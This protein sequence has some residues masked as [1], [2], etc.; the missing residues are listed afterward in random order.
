MIAK[1]GVRMKALG[2]DGLDGEIDADPRGFD[3][4][5]LLDDCFGDRELAALLQGDHDSADGAWAPGSQ[6]HGNHHDD[7]SAAGLERDVPRSV[8]EI[9]LL[10]PAR[11]ILSRPS[12]SFRATLV[13]ASYRLARG[14]RNGEAGSAHGASPPPELGALVEIV[15]AGSLVVDDVQDDSARR[16]GAATLHRLYGVPLAINTG[17]WLYFWPLELLSE[18][19]PRLG[20]SAH[21]EADLRRRFGRAMFRCHF[22]QALDLAVHVARLPQRWVPSVVRGAAELKT[23]TLTELAATV[24]AVAAGASAAHLDALARFGRRLGLGLQMLDDLGN[25]TTSAGA[26]NGLRP[27]GGLPGGRHAGGNR[28]GGNQ[29]GDARPDRKAREDKQLEDL[30]NGRPTWPWA[31]AAEHLPPDEFASLQLELRVLSAQAQAQGQEQWADSVDFRPL[32]ETLR[33]AVGMSGRRTAHLT[34]ERALAD[35]QAALGPDAAL[36]DLRTMVARLEA[37]YG[38]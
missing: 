20:L 31:L 4:A 25:L 36:D 3:M 27:D 14:T 13:A 1:A 33:N 32:A 7:R 26:P 24:G 17:N 2:L 34:L 11:D 21:V 10:G 19:A 6:T 37:A 30:Q 22:G 9:A 18:L 28:D 29:D 23:A 38:V 5:G 35:L 12:K 8:W 15:H 16:R